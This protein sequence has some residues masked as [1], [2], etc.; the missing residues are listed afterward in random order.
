[1][2][3]HKTWV[4]ETTDLQIGTSLS[5]DL[6]DAEGN[7]LHKAGAPITDRLLERLK[8]RNIHSL[9][10][11][12]Q[13]ESH[14]PSVIDA[15][16]QAYPEDTIQGIQS[17]AD[18]AE[19]SLRTLSQQI[20]LHEALDVSLVTE[21]VD[22]FTRQAVQ[23]AAATLA[24]LAS[25]LNRLSDSQTEQWISRST[26]LA[27]LGIVTAVT[28]DLP[29]EDTR[30]TGLAGLLHDC[31]TIMHPEWFDELDG[32]ASSH[33]LLESYKNHP[34]E[35]VQLLQTTGLS[36]RVLAAIAQVHEQM[37]GSG[38]PNCLSNSQLLTSA[39]ILNVADA[40]LS[41]VQPFFNRQGVLW[42]D[43]VAFLCYHASNRRFDARIVRG[44]VRGLSMY[45]VGSV[46]ELDDQSIALVI[47]GNPVNPL[48]PLVQLLGSDLKADLGTSPRYIVGPAKKFL[49]EVDRIS[50]STLQELLWRYDLG[51]A[52]SH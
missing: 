9:T 36:N 35:S 46:V 49:G 44:F 25:R 18:F 12:G 21:T 28:L 24:V 5:F 13:V 38:F 33:E 48:E 4:I 31:S 34:Q 45:P 3:D 2:S 8:K 30:E 22:E 10:V 39:R 16:L 51:F 7:V 52:A 37:D 43:A 42:S 26:S 6:K 11:Q 23:D 14:E 29:D 41:L 17:A 19:Q 1:M 47:R 32:I 40:Y 50:K 27:M 15:L 20:H